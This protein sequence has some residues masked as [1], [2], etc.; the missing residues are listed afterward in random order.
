MVDYSKWDK[1]ELLSDDSDEGHPNIDKESLKRWK[2]QAKVQKR[3]EERIQEETERQE[4]SRLE[5]DGSNESSNQI[6]IGQL[7]QKLDKRERTRKLDENL[8]CHEGFSKTVT[9]YSHD[10]N[11]R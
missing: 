5:K 8:L 2:K 10:Q 3:E 1:I 4:L 7:H 6:R 9:I 11:D